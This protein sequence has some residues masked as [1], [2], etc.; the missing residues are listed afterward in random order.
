MSS[1]APL[2]RE[3]RPGLRRAN[4][5]WRADFR[6]AMAATGHTHESVAAV[7]EVPRQ[8]VT[9]M[10]SPHGSR[11]LSLDD[12][13][14]LSRDAASRDLWVEFLRLQCE[15]AGVRRLDCE[16]LNQQVEQL[17]EQATRVRAAVRRVG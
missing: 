15:R 1:L 2:P 17:V 7:L 4:D 10:L 16:A 8:H 6:R 13:D 12:V 9:D 14:A 5:G 3:Q 11:K